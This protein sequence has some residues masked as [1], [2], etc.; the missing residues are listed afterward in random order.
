VPL[1]ETVQK[2]LDELA[3]A[4]MDD[5]EDMMSMVH[6]LLLAIWSSVWDPKEDNHLPF[7]ASME[8]GLWVNHKECH[9]TSASS[10][11]ACS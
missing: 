8:M 9:Q 1:L 6:E 2:A 3:S 5:E 7:V 10:N 11:A 4:V